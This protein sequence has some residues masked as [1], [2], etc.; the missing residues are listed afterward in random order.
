MAAGLPAGLAARS[1]NS[2]TV[3]PQGALQK[4]WLPPLW[5]EAGTPTSRAAGTEGLPCLWTKQ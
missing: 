3:W 5:K 4:L 2:A 1:C